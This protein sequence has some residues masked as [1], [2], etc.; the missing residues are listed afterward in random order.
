[1]PARLRRSRLQPKR[2]PPRVSAL[3]ARPRSRIEVAL[4]GEHWR[5]LP[6]EVV[7]AAGL[8]VGVELDRERARRLRRELLRC[9]ASEK[10]VRSLARRDLSRRELDE[11]L[12]RAKIVPA[13]RSEALGRLVRAGA[14]DDERFAQRR[15]QELAERGAGD[16]L[17]RH[18]LAERGIG[19]QLTADAIDAV[20]PEAA[21]A[22]RIVARRGASPKTIRHLARKGFSEDTIEG[23]C[24]EDVAGP[25]QGAVP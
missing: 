25:T 10:A 8:D 16:A 24:G 23:V 6:A 18:D 5:T 4:D 11:R 12:A 22:A 19:A 15:A 2:S 7:L 1:M 20:E 14:V 3:V 13:A 9:E 21:R 17:I